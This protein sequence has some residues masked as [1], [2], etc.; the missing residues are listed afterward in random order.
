MTSESSAVN[1]REHSHGGGNLPQKCCDPDGRCG[2]RPEENSPTCAVRYGIL[3]NVGEFRYAP[4]VLTGCGGRV[5]IQTCRGIEIGERVALTCTGCDR[6]IDRQQMWAY[7][8]H[9]GS[10]SYQLKAGRILREATE[11]DLREEAKINAGSHKKLSS[12][13]KLAESRGLLMKFIACE[14]LF[15]G[16]RIILHFMAESRV[17]FREL[18]RDLAHEYHT[19][20]EMHQI[21]ARDEARLVAD[22][23]ICGRECCCKNF[24]KKLRPV[25]MRM[26]KLQKATLDPSKVSGRCGRLRCCLRFENEG[27]EELNKKLPRVGSRVRTEQGIAT[28]KDRHVLTQLLAIQFDDTERVET[29]GIEAVLETGLPKR[30]PQAAASSGNKQMTRREAAGAAQEPQP[31]PAATERGDKAS[32]VEGEPPERGDRR[33]RRRSSRKRPRT[34]GPSPKAKADEATAA[35]AAANESVSVGR[36]AELATGPQPVDDVI[37]PSHADED[38]QSSEGDTAKPGKRS[39]RRRRGGGR[40]RGRDRRAKARHTEPKGSASSVAKTESTRDGKPT[41]KPNNHPPDGSRRE[42]D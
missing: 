26:A 3:G 40:G 4:N 14:H 20:I 1:N 13:K 22:Y 9:S 23:E 30:T 18:V 15:G 31:K 8:R 28:V 12:A 2:E 25:T 39:S 35:P 38:T 42:S 5:V 21:G 7:A 41:P 19:R 16:E 32:Q 36:D 37:A 33:R 34:A 24:L 11:Q 6:S 27:Y 10:E 17:D 29:V